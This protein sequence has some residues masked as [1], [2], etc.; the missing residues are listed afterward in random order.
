MQ[1]V[2]EEDV[3]YSLLDRIM[4]PSILL[5]QRPCCLS[6]EQTYKIVR[7]FIQDNI[8]SRW[9]SITSDHDFCFTV[10][11]RL[12]LPAPKEYTVNV[13]AFSKR[14]PRCQ[15][16]TE[17]EHEETCFEMTYSPKNYDRYTPIKGFTAKTQ[18]ELNEKIN[19][20][21]QA[22]IRDI[23]APLKDCPQCSGSGV[24]LDK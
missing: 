19:E 10:K 16:R 2:T 7:R 4:Y 14:K 5:S 11:R 17:T 20:Y 23:N 13:N 22:L 18:P 24:V 8:D 21:C 3:F 9:A 6:S 15:R 1:Q 12:R